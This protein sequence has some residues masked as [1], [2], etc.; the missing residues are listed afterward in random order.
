MARAYW[1]SKNW[2]GTRQGAGR[3]TPG[4]PT[5]SISITLPED[6]IDAVDKLAYQQH[7]TRSAVIARYLTQAL[8]KTVHTQS[9]QKNNRRS[10]LGSKIV[11][12]QDR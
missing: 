1:H 12:S 9:D 8:N 7:A 10:Q 3:P 11:G 5:R 4:S 6:L 2:G